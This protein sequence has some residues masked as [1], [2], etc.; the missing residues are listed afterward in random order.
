MEK[1]K[2]WIKKRDMERLFKARC[3]AYIIGQEAPSLAAQLLANAHLV[4]GV[5]PA[6]MA[7]FTALQDMSDEESA[8]VFLYT[9]LGSQDPAAG[10]IHPLTEPPTILSQVVACG[11]LSHPWDSGGMTYLDMVEAVESWASRPGKQFA[12]S[13]LFLDDNPSA[14]HGSDTARLERRVSKAPAVEG[15]GRSVVAAR[16]ALPHLLAGI[17]VADLERRNAEM[18]EKLLES[19]GQLSDLQFEYSR[20]LNIC[21]KS[22]E[23]GIIHSISLTGKEEAYAQVVRRVRAVVGSTLPTDSAVAVVSKGDAELLKLDGRKGWHF[24]CTNDGVYAGHYPATSAAAIEQLKNLINKGAEY[25]IFPGT[26]FWWFDHYGEFKRHLDSTAE[27]VAHEDTVCVIYALTPLAVSRALHTQASGMEAQLKRKRDEIARRKVI[28]QIRKLA[29]SVLPHEATVLVATKG[30]D[31]L[32]SLDGRRTWH[33]PQDKRGA[34]AAHEIP[35]GDGRAAVAHLESLQTN[36]AEYLL[37]PAWSAAWVL[38]HRELQRHLKKNCTALAEQAGL[39]TIYA[40]GKPS[41]KPSTR[42][43]KSPA[44]CR[45][46]R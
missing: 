24:P 29:G 25:L 35:T 40:I 36:G 9:S 26:M 5:Q 32:F 46:A 2:I 37:V 3:V 18:S 43:A 19:L 12:P 22:S 30:E 28:D 41:R 10:D 15:C 6:V 44:R 21:A 33:F 42:R 34:R 4:P 20:L 8:P 45:A 38:G 13:V 1:V 11:T 7:P 23:T 16:D 27:M 17:Y 39:A 31:A 14:E